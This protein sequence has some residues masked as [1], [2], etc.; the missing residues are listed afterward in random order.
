MIRCGRCFGRPAPTRLTCP[1]A[2]N[3]GK[4]S[5][6]CRCPGVH[7]RVSTWPCPS[8]RRCTLVLNPPWLRPHASAAGAFFCSSG[9]L[10]GSNHG[11]IDI[12]HVPV[13]LAVGV[14]V[15]LHCREQPLP[16]PSLLPA[17]KTT[18]DRA[19]GAIAFGQIA[20]G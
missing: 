7:T 9:M 3:G 10:V 2:L 20:P 11:A 16:D 14:G 1:P 12:L 19:P 6:S 17:V 8:A 18:G 13:D 15:G 5:A 4:I